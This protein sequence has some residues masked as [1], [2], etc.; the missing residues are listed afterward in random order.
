MS[1]SKLGGLHVC[2]F[3]QGSPTSSIQVFQCESG[4]LSKDLNL[5]PYFILLISLNLYTL[6]VARSTVC[7][8]FLQS[9]DFSLEVTGKLEEHSLLTSCDNLVMYLDCSCL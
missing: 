3:P 5:Y 8:A 4:L 6:T 9:V 2:N 7:I 1:F